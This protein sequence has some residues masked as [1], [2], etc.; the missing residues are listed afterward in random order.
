MTVQEMLDELLLKYPHSYTNAQ[1]VS[2]MDRLQKR[3]FRNL[4]TLAYD[5]YSP[6]L[7]TS[8]GDYTY[9]S[10]SY[11]NYQIRRLL[12][13]GIEYPYWTPEEDKPARFWFYMNSNI[14]IYPK[15]I[16]KSIDV[17]IWY[18]VKPTALSAASLNATP[19]L[20]SDYHMMLVYGVAKEIAEDMRDGSMATSFAVSYNDLE[21]EMM[22]SYQNPETYVVKE[23]PWG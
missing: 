1:V 17:E 20:L 10:S 12:I 23:I 9:L 19:E 22:Q 15:S 11:E 2:R 13:D 8:M 18:Y 6:T 4:N 7:S 16:G 3:I 21:N 14:Y 5:F